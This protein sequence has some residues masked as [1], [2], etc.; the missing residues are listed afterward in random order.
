MGD[1]KT[2]PQ[3]PACTSSA[4][5]LEPLQL[6]GRSSTTFQ[7]SHLSPHLMAL[8]KSEPE[9]DRARLVEALGMKVLFD[10]F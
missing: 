2:C 3:A 9:M 7:G 1:S 6:P 4:Y 10:T 8:K 5:L